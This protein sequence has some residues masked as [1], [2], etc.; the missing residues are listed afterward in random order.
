MR[1]EIMIAW[2]FLV[3]LLF[4]LPVGA[5]FGIAK[6]EAYFEVQHPPEVCISGRKLQLEVHGQNPAAQ[7]ATTPLR[8]FLEPQLRR[9][10]FELTDA[11]P[12]TRLRLLVEQ[13]QQR[14]ELR[15]EKEEHSISLGR[16]AGLFGREKCE[17]QVLTVYRVRGHGSLSFSLIL[18][19]VAAGTQLLNVSLSAND[20][21]DVAVA[22]PKLC[23]GKDYEGVRRD[24]TD[25][26]SLAN[27]LTG[28]VAEVTLQRQFFG[29]IEQK[30]V[31][32]AT[33]DELKPG[34]MF[35]RG[36]RWKEALEIWQTVPIKESKTEAYRHYNLGVAYEGLAYASPELP[37]ALDF[38]QQ[39]EAAYKKAVQ[40]HPKEKYFLP[41]FTRLDEARMVFERKREHQAC[42][43]A[44]TLKRGPSNVAVTL[45]A[46]Q[47]GR[48]S[49][50]R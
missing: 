7:I 16:E 39:A 8:A 31:L 20:Y 41:A 47:S 30:E 2:A 45:E 33:P 49:P 24:L 25:L 23:G 48:I 14:I 36:K 34:N 4:A 38:L 26:A 5:Q 15:A 18:E 1:R 21:V 10:G 46:Q 12:E 35:A 43:Q 9:S 17:S 6:T 22:G 3:P 37:Q 44:E 32:L 27:Y 50:K 42:R 13:F 29:W 19:D 11:Q 40:L 28:R